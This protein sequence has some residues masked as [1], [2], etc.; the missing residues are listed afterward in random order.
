MSSLKTPAQSYL[1]MISSQGNWNLNLE[2]WGGRETD[3]FPH[4]YSTTW[5]CNIN[6]YWKS[7]LICWN[8]SS[9]LII[10][11]RLCLSVMIWL[12][13]GHRTVFSIPGLTGDTG[14]ALIGRLYRMFLCVSLWHDTRPQAGLSCTERIYYYI[15][16]CILVPGTV[17]GIL[18]THESWLT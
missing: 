18:M 11:G 13:D 12:S 9:W 16:V 14:I 1:E 5:F 4:S 7:P 17:S 3:S 10:P 15:D 8:Y 6:V 2:D